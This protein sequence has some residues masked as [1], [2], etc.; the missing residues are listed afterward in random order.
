MHIFRVPGHPGRIIASCIHVG[1]LNIEVASRFFFGKFVHTWAGV[2]I[3]TLSLK[4]PTTSVVF[5]LVLIC[6]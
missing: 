4:T 1:T 6:I 2:I 5:I 3:L